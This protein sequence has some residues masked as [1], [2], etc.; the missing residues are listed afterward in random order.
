VL[1]GR[2][3]RADDKFGVET[4]L[5][6]TSDGRLLRVVSK[7]LDVTDIPSLENGLLEQLFSG[8]EIRAFT[9]S[10]ETKNNEAMR[11]NLIGRHFWRKRDPENIQKAIAA[12]QHAIDLDPGYS[13]AYAGLADSYVLMSSVAYG[14]ASPQE[15]FVR[16]RA[17]AK[18]ALEID[19][20]NAEAHTSLG[21]VL[22]KHD[23]NWQ[24]AEREYRRAIEIDPEN[25]GAH[26]WLSGLLGITGRAAESIAVA[27]KAKELDPFSPLVEYNLARAYYFARQYD[28]A[29]E[30]LNRQTITEKN[31][32]KFRFHTGYIYLMTGREPEALQAFQEVF[33][34]NKMLGIAALG[35]TH[36]KMGRRKDALNLLAELER[37]AKESYVPPQEIAIIYIGLGEKDKAFHYLNEAYKERYGSLTAI[38]VEP[39]FDPIRDDVR[40]ADLLRQMALNN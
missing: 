14:S 20:L 1:T 31:D 7:E 23:W 35:Y 12:F 6:D 3:Y 40:F 15:S 28:R 39:L 11:Q 29:L 38:K 10:G 9:E 36:A 30:V 16:A 18:Q 22:T 4:R 33:A 5:I 37:T 21:V 24:E 32:T 25:A 2:I 17:A 26:Y 19:P 27:E 34:K 8:L 13:R